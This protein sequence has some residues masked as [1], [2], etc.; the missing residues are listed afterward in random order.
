[1]KPD[2]SPKSVN[3][4]GEVP[5]VADATISVPYVSIAELRASEVS[6]GSLVSLTA[7]NGVTLTLAQTVGADSD[8]EETITR[9]RLNQDSV[10]Y[11]TYVF[12]PSAKNPFYT[13][14]DSPLA[15]GELEE[16]LVGAT[17]EAGEY[18]GYSSPSNVHGDF[19]VHLNRYDPSREGEVEVVT[20][21]A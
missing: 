7:E 11:V 12:Q 16:Y 8:I 6:E 4:L 20:T 17:H 18:A 21:A 15:E 5:G 9:S 19:L 10:P 3:I 13:V 2:N 1:M 14:Y